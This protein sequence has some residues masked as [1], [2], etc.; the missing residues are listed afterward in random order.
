MV[1]SL[2]LDKISEEIAKHKLQETCNLAKSINLNILY[3]SY[4]RLRNPSPGYFLSR[5]ILNKFKKIIEDME[6]K[7]IIFNN[8]LS[9]VQQRNLEKFYNLKVRD[10]THL[11]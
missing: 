6:I 7:L 3:S 9:P 1:L 4:L 11:I 8:S 2:H 5:G 10:R